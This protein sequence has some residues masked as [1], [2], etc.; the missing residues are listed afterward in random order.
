MSGGAAV[1]P[2]VLD[3][4]VGDR[5]VT[6]IVF[7]G[8]SCRA[9]LDTGSQVTTVTEDFVQSSLPDVPI[10][11]VEDF[12]MIH[13]AGRQT[14]PYLG[15]IEVDICP[16]PDSST[17]VF[18]VLA[19]VLSGDPYCPTVPVIV[20]MNF[21]QRYVA[22]SAQLSH[23]RCW[24]TVFRN[25]AFLK[26]KGG[27]LGHVT[28]LNA[29]TL[30]PGERR[31]IR[32]ISRTGS[33]VPNSTFLAMT[34]SSWDSSLPGGIFLT[35]SVSTLDSKDIWSY[36]VDVELTNLSRRP[37]DIPARSS[38]CDL[39][40]VSEERD[41]SPADESEFLSQVKWPEDP[42]ARQ[43]LETLLLKWRHIFA[44]SDFDLRYTSTVEHRINLTDETPIR[45]RSRRIPPSMYQE[46][47]KHIQDMLDAGHIRPSKSPWSFPVVLVRK[48]CGG[49]RFC[50]DFRKLNDRTIRDGYNVPRIDET[51]DALAGS[52]MFSCLDLRS[53]Y[54]QVQMAEEHK[55]RTAF[56]VGPLGFYE[57]NS[58][59]F[60]LTNCPATFQRLMEATLSDVQHDQCLVFFDDIVV[61]SSGLEENISRL[62]S[63][64][65][66]LEVAGL[67]LKPSKC[68]FFQS[69]I[70]YLGH[71]VSEKGIST[72]PDKVSSVVNW[73]R[74]TC[75]KE[76]QQFIGFAGFYRRFIEGFSKV[77][78]PLNDLLGGSPKSRGKR[79]KS[80]SS[81]PFKWTDE[82]EESFK[83]LKSCLV[84]APVLGFADYSKPFEVHTDASS[85]GL[86]SVLYQVQE[87]QKRVI[88]Y[89]SRALKPAER[90][91]PA[92]KLEFLALKWAV[93]DK[94][95]DYLYAQRFEVW[96]D[97]NPLTCVLSSAR[98]D[99]VGHRWLARLASY[100]FSIHYKSGSTNID[101]DAL[102]R[103]PIPQEVVQAVCS[104]EFPLSQIGL[105]SSLPV[106]ADVVENFFASD[107]VS[108]LNVCQLQSEDPCISLVRQWKLEGRRPTKEVLAN[109]SQGVK[110]LC[111]H[112]DKLT[113]ID[114]VLCRSITVNETSVS[115]IV[116]PSSSHDHV[117]QSLHDDLGHPG[118]DKT[119]SL[120]RQRFFW[121]KMDSDI[122]NRISS[123]R[124]CVCRK[125]QGQKAPLVPVI[126][127]QPL[128]LL[129]IDY[130]LVEPSHGFEHLLVMVDHFTKFACVVPTRNE[131]ARTTANA[132]FTHFVN[133]FGYPQAIHSDQGR[134]F[135]SAIIKE[136]C[137]IA[138]VRKSRTTP[139]HP[140]GN[141]ACERLNQTLLKLL[142]TL[143]AEKK[144][145]W[146]DY[147]GALVQ[148]YN[149]TPHEATGYSPYELL[150]GRA[151]RLPID[152]QV[153]GKAPGG[154]RNYSKYM[155]DLRDRVAFA[156]GLVEKRLGQ[157]AEALS[158]KSS[159]PAVLSVGDQVLVR[160]V[161]LVGR[162][163]LADRWE[164]DLFV[165]LEKPNPDI[166]VYRVKPKDSG[167]RVRTLHRNLLLPVSGLATQSSK[168]SP[169]RRVPSVRRN[170]SLSSSCSSSALCD[171]SSSDEDMCLCLSTSSDSEA[172]VRPKRTRKPPDR[173]GF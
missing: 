57:F 54:W 123:C 127:T 76:V 104:V 1:S 172:D 18:P 73:P 56:N 120:I 87:G 112:W 92:H 109:S 143:E 137:S 81:V 41:E 68:T 141:G 155:E 134:N 64:F 118:R 93:T 154:E 80:K 16:D 90:N 72:D 157:K 97:N 12:L 129:C 124:R 48:R 38:L 51:L 82:H 86:G 23:S 74:P 71:V 98:L 145:R 133:V 43:Q 32:G 85:L 121:P 102:S 111:R 94:F 21:M 66:R 167:G 130:L 6:S 152:L 136:L 47:K 11:P 122:S 50:V 79:S 110:L 31:H 173:F 162:N 24:Q 36:H 100:N 160:K 58:M 107:V 49:L 29:E 84:S 42:K 119:S 7:G 148:A 60:G 53:G 13:G 108:P 22:E 95:N 115:Q 44:L 5:N 166:P 77:A 106:S 52:N 8:R 165:V 40:L 113:V 70:R 10:R 78:R 83:Q 62:E 146:K 14:L 17:E 105:V 69:T 45:E 88:S 135:E 114:D 39:H 159:K 147:L 128:E 169:S 161:G 59:P 171:S 150:F 37:I 25:L 142:G 144:S 20:G 132:L 126:T 30:Q 153:K 55:E 67:K 4:L 46:T 156:H 125:A 158:G 26:S 99:A 103:L 131:S 27:V 28:S 3:K 101:A 139:Y 35:P 117:F 151:P 61:F 65:K 9:L 75:V 163:K 34:E 164:E 168:S 89:A 63:V 33:C 96:T 116:L 140:M 149:S 2:S 91:Y 138:G 19:L 15:Y 170:N